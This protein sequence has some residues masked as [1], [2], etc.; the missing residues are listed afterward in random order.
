MLSIRQVPSE[1]A[2]ATPRLVFLRSPNVGSVASLQDS[3]VAAQYRGTRESFDRFQKMEH[4]L[5]LV[6][7]RSFN[8]HLQYS[9]SPHSGHQAS[10]VVVSAIRCRDIIIRELIYPFKILARWERR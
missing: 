1:A 4:D 2:S 6:L 9:S 5:L 8:L 7:Y 3:P 10:E